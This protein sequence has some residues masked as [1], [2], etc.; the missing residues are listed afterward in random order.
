MKLSILIPCYNEVATIEKVLHRVQ[1]APWP[2]KEIIVV[3]DG[4]TDGTAELLRGDLASR[5]DQ[6]VFHPDNRGKGAAVRTGLAQVTGQ[7]VIIQDADLEYDPEAY[8]RLVKPIVEDLADAVFG[9]RFIGPGPHR[10][11]YFRHYL[12][13]RLLTFVSNLFSDLNL[14]DMETGCKAFR[15]EVLQSLHLQ[16]DRFGFEPEVTAKLARSGRRVYEIGI[17]YHGRTYA[18]GK[19]ITWRDGLHALYCILRYNL[20]A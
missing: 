1:S 6:V 3:D 11:M 19:K 2:D 12:G 9:S 18:E 8:P 15:T 16:E 20:L 17:P 5:A 14:T 10:C 7:I 4:S 13:N